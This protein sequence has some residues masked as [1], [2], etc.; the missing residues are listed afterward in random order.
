MQVGGKISGVLQRT[1]NT[2]QSRGN[3]GLAINLD[4]TVMAVSLNDKDKI[5]L[6]RC[7]LLYTRAHAHTHVHT[8]TRARALSQ[9]RTRALETTSRLTRRVCSSS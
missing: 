2:D 6:F 4:G 5:L 3:A 8:H 9:T 7:A 1:L